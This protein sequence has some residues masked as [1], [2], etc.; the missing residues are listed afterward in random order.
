MVQ[1]RLSLLEET[2]QTFVFHALP[3]YCHRA[4]EEE[5][6]GEKAGGGREIITLE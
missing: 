1:S 3:Q 5:R 4:V 2:N 6:E